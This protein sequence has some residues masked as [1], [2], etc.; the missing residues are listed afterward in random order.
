MLKRIAVY[1]MSFLCVCLFIL[2]YFWFKNRQIR[3]EMEKDS[4]AFFAEENA[5]KNSLESLGDVDLNPSDMSL[6]KLEERL[7]QPA[8]RK[9]GAGNTTRLGWACGQERCAIWTS[10]VVPFDKEIPL[11]AAPTALVV[12][13]PLLADF[14]RLAIGGVHLGD[15]TEKIRDIC[16]KRGYGL[17]IG[18]N[19]ISWSKDWN[20]VWGEVNGKV[21]LLAF[22]NEKMLKNT[23][24]HGDGNHSDPISI[25]K[26][27]GK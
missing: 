15:K 8:I 14:R 6:E 26:G 12:T 25:R 21:S 10:F 24:T 2:G 4:G 27:N 9:A 11:S 3:A 23:E 7:H 5:Q 18:Y 13:D 17:Q 22:F 19:R 1:C 16:Q 20:L